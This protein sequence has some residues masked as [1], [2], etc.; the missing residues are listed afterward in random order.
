ME[1]YDMDKDEAEDLREFA[2]GY[3]LDT[4]DAKVI[5]DFL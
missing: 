2:D 4:G 5:R 1:E 3:G